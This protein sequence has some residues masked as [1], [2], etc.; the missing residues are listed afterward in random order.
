MR[1]RIC[2]DNVTSIN[3]FLTIEKKDYLATL[4]MPNEKNADR[5]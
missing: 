1:E 2:F 5:R 3:R 4:K